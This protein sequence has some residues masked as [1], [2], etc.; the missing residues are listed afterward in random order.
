LKEGDISEGKKIISY[1]TKANNNINA[2]SNVNHNLNN[3]KINSEDSDSNEK[4]N[5]E[6]SVNNNF[7]KNNHNFRQTQSQPV[8]RRNAGTITGDDNE[9]MDEVTNT[10]MQ[11][12]YNSRYTKDS[13]DAIRYMETVVRN[14]L[15]AVQFRENVVRA[16]GYIL[17]VAGN[18]SL[19]D[20]QSI[21]LNQIFTVI[22]E[23]R[24]YFF[25]LL[26][27]IRNYLPNEASKGKNVEIETILK[28][29]SINLPKYMRCAAHFLIRE[30]HYNNLNIETIISTYNPSPIVF[31]FFYRID[32]NLLNSVIFS[33]IDILGLDIKIDTREERL[34]ENILGPVFVHIIKSILENKTPITQKLFVTI[35][36]NM[37]ISP[38]DPVL[39][40]N[41]FYMYKL[42]IRN[43]IPGWNKC[44]KEMNDMDIYK[45]I[46]TS[47]VNILKV[48]KGNHNVINAI[49]YI[50]SH[51]H[52]ITP[53]SSSI[54]SDVDEN[55]KT[56]LTVLLQKMIYPDYDKVTIEFKN[57]LVKVIEDS[58]FNTRFISSV[59]N[60]F[61][62]DN[63][64]DLLLGSL[65][66][67]HK[68][69]MNIQMYAEVTKIIPILISSLL[70]KKEKI[71]FVRSP[72]R[73]LRIVDL[74]PW[75]SL[76]GTKVVNINPIV[77]KLIIQNDDFRL[78]LTTLV[79]LEQIV[80]YDPMECLQLLLK[81]EQ[82]LVPGDVKNILSL[83][84][85]NNGNIIQA[86]DGNNKKPNVPK[87]K[88]KTS[89]EKPENQAQVEDTPKEESETSKPNIKNPKPSRDGNGTNEVYEETPENN[90][91]HSK[92]KHPSKNKPYHHQLIEPK[93]SIKKSDDL[94]DFLTETKRSQ[95]PNI[96]DPESLDDEETQELI[97]EI[98]TNQ[99]VIDDPADI[100]TIKPKDMIEILTTAIEKDANTLGDEK[101]KAIETYLNVL[102]KLNGISNIIIRQEDPYEKEIKVDFN[103]ILNEV[104]CFNELPL[105]DKIK[106]TEIL[107]YI[108]KNPSIINNNKINLFT[109]KTKAKFVKYILETI[110]NQQ[111]IDNEIR[112]YI[113]IIIPYIKFN[114]PGAEKL[115]FENEMV[116]K[117]DK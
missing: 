53:F 19:T 117:E 3:R 40:E 14:I 92:T 102:E 89:I 17:Q 6:V 96:I 98:L 21:A 11:N 10:N 63:P 62:Y 85:S 2:N 104:I 86:I 109:H 60:R 115:I 45:M 5:E 107:Q 65:T 101:I 32:T 100:K 75:M 47:L 50:Y 56:M 49:M 25:D 58:N 38:F 46:K 81:K 76:Q 35:L 70:F 87:N 55:D 52:P 111:E 13:S 1:K 108:E 29:I 74:L 41:I 73:E 12:N 71:T 77:N 72:Y 94:N 26:P 88:P 15:V 90:T 64:W 37:P 80:C 106:F 114:G 34:I 67:L 20:E 110:M 103:Q 99:H 24:V 57:R 78:M 116:V 82:T 28:I 66:L 97:L 23:K 83:A 18:N 27:P 69:I 44:K 51:L 93:R 59:F 8:T 43:K 95:K 30:L 36:V 54:V 61:I 4:N 7:N 31:N 33:K 22:R 91:E 112:K 105:S 42:G 113:K 48:Q 9:E 79:A 39:E 68:N 84:P 16:F